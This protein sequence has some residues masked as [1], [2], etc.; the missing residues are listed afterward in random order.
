MKNKKEVVAVNDSQILR[1][2][3]QLNGIQDLDAEVKNIKTEIKRIKKE[4][5]SRENK[6]KIEKLYD[7]L[8]SLQYQKD[9]FCM[10]MNSS[11]DYDKASISALSTVS[12]DIQK[13]KSKITAAGLAALIRPIGTAENTS[14]II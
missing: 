2:I 13:I 12:P 10:I 11:K 14:P 3:S 8:F 4:P 7:K 9:Y 1:W 5:K 6:D